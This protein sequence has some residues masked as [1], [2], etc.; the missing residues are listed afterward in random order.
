VASVSGP[1]FMLHPPLGHWTLP[2]QIPQFAP[3]VNESVPQPPQA[4]VPGSEHETPD[5]P[6]VHAYV[7]QLPQAAP[8]SDRIR[9]MPSGK[10]S[11][12]PRKQQ[13]ATS[14]H[15]AL[16][17]RYAALD[18]EQLPSGAEFFWLETGKERLVL[19]SFPESAPVG[20]MEPKWT[21]QLTPAE[22]S[23]LHHLLLGHSDAS[24]ARARKRSP[25]TIGHQVASIFRKVGVNSRR[26]LLAM[27]REW[28]TAAT[29][30]PQQVPPVPDP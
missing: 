30:L 11:L 22:S 5:L 3:G 28:K 15:V 27:M 19:L 10:R 25:R 8:G 12:T 2:P 7:P 13:G 9:A 21:C 1:W 26:E 20:A 4:L 16:L 23:I 24:I 6:A 29:A 17:S 14:A 18:P